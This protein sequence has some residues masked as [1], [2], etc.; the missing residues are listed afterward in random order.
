MSALTSRM[1]F[2]QAGDEPSLRASSFDDR[3]D[4]PSERRRP[5][6]WTVKVMPLYL[7]CDDEDDGFS[8]LQSLGQHF[9]AL[10]LNGDGGD[11]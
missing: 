3:V 5:I 9:H 11:D 4:S 10:L 1:M 8:L 2:L 6:T 7:K